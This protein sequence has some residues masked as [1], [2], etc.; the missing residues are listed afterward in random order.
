M[1]QIN[2][3]RSKK[4][5]SNKCYRE[6]QKT[7]T[8]FS[9]RFSVNLRAFEKIETTGSRRT[10]LTRTLPKLLLIT[11]SFYI[12]IVSYPST[13]FVFIKYESDSSVRI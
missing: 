13:G 1:K 9:K 5:V 3:R 8:L 11:L 6:K 4:N 7:Y 2:I 12:E 10:R